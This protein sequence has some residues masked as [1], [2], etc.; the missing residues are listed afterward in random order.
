MR[1]VIFAV[2]GS[3]LALTPIGSSATTDRYVLW[4]ARTAGAQPTPLQL[5]ADLPDGVPQGSAIDVIDRTAA[6]RL[7]IA[8]REEVVIENTDGSARVALPIADVYDGRFSPDGSLLVLADS[9]HHLSIV[10]S[11]GTS[12]RT[13]AQ[14]AGPAR[15][16]GNRMLAYVSALRADLTGTLVVAGT[17]GRVLRVLGRSFG[18]PGAPAPSPNGTLIADQCRTQLV[19]IRSTRAPYRVVARF[20]GSA[21]TPL[22][23][24]DGSRIA[25]NIGGNYT[26]NTAVGNVK[27]A[28]LHRI[29]TPKYIHTDDSVIAWS[30]DSTTILVQR[31]CAGERVCSDQV[32]SERLSTHARRRL[33]HDNLKWESVRWTKAS[34]TYIT[35]PSA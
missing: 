18:F 15:W 26:T 33:T 6:G 11:D 16:L 1:W 34:L 20:R 22:W 21:D 29:S 2:V 25:L 23:S 12:L 31:R 13:L 27:T 4:S 8:T 7:A 3:A 32:F 14:P 10:D 35:P 9:N 28:K 5:P 30:P 17:S 24:P 19:C